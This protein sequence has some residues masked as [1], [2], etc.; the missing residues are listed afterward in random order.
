MMGRMLDP[1]ARPGPPSDESAREAALDQLH[2]MLVRA[3]RFEVG[4]RRH[5]LGHIPPAEL[6]AL[7]RKAADDAMDVVLA[8]LDECPEG[9]RFATWCCKF[10]LLEA[11]VQAVRREWRDR[12]VRVDAGEWPAT[13]A[14]TRHERE[15]FSAL[16]LHGVPI[17]VLAER[18]GTTR[19]ALYATLRTARGKLRSSLSPAGAASEASADGRHEASA[20]QVV[21]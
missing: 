17:D 10:A 19:G 21:E 15:V 11:R 6:D 13:D 9:R 1:M 2:A 18:L 14:L 5:R 3:A 4:R 16:A 7:A 8:R 12:D 20:A